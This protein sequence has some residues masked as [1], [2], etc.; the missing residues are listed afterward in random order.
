MAPLPPADNLI[1]AVVVITFWK[2]DKDWAVATLLRTPPSRYKQDAV[3]IPRPAKAVYSQLF[4]LLAV[5]Q[6]SFA[7]L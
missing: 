2:H 4:F 5:C 1:A 7:C 6:R 3:A